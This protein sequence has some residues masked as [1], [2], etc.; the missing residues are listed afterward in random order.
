ML[1][2]E[3]ETTELLEGVFCLFEVLL[4]ILSGGDLDCFFTRRF[5]L[6]RGFTLESMKDK[7]LSARLAIEGGRLL[8]LSISSARIFLFSV[9][10]G[11]FVR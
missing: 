2:Q 9:L 10:E 3:E 4:Q 5:F 11:E 7:Q 8:I 1:S 6:R